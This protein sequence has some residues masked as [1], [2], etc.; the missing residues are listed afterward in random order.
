M[1]ASFV[2]GVLCLLII[3]LLIGLSQK[4]SPKSDPKGS[5]EG[6]CGSCSAAA[7]PTALVKFGTHAP[8][9]TKSTSKVCS[10]CSDQPGYELKDGTEMQGAVE[11]PTTNAV[12]NKIYAQPDEILSKCMHG[13]Q[14]DSSTLVPTVGCNQTAQCV[15]ISYDTTQNVCTLL[16]S[17]DDPS[18]TSSSSTVSTYLKNCSCGG[19]ANTADIACG[20]NVY[21]SQQCPTG[22]CYG[23]TVGQQTMSAYCCMDGSEPGGCTVTSNGLSSGVFIPYMFYGEEEDNFSDTE[24]CVVDGSC[25]VI[26]F[27]PVGSYN[28]DVYVNT[29]TAYTSRLDDP[30]GTRSG[31]KVAECRLENISCQNDCVTEVGYIVGFPDDILTDSVDCPYVA[32]SPGMSLLTRTPD[33]LLLIKGRMY[34]RDASTN[35]DTLGCA[36][37]FS[38]DAILA[39]LMTNSN[40]TDWITLFARDTV[41]QTFLRDPRFDPTTKFYWHPGYI[42][43]DGVPMGIKTS[44]GKYSTVWVDPN[45]LGDEAAYCQPSKNA[46][47]LYGNNDSKILLGQAPACSVPFLAGCRTYTNPDGYFIPGGIDGKVSGSGTTWHSLNSYGNDYAIAPTV[48]KTSTLEQ[49]ESN[50]LYKIPTSNNNNAYCTEM[51]NADST[52]SADDGLCGTTCT[53]P[54]VDDESVGLKS[55]F[56]QDLDEQAGDSQCAIA[57]KEVIG[58]SQYYDY[59]RSWCLRDD[60]DSLGLGLSNSCFV[61][62]VRKVMSGNAGDAVNYG[63]TY[64][65]NSSCTALS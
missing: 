33:T 27:S 30:E 29:Y 25:P 32:S 45:S 19:G 58:N 9:A 57:L 64:G 13:G 52:N 54:S 43:S 16:G 10:K 53:M 1:Y 7:I 5:P 22:T 48:Y 2:V 28:V 40:K 37:M 31:R 35:D 36:P 56:C 15:G 49:V 62:D 3:I 26:S 6:E 51:D 24:G 59:S 17:Y 14:I 39:R 55:G 42:T 38:Q 11:L 50:K 20:S 46:T 23:D 44:D 12:P 34:S 61:N 21:G 41:L 63:L 4:G 8:T 47:K 60:G 18:M 65:G